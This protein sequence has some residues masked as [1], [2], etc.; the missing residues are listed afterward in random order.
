MADSSLQARGNAIYQYP[1]STSLVGVDLS[2]SRGLLLAADAAGNLT[3]NASTTVPAAAICLDGQIATKSS[4]IGI[5]E[6]MP[7]PTFV[8]LSGT[9]APFQR[10]QQ[11]A[12]GGVVVDVGPG[13]ARVVVGRLGDQGGVAGD[14]VPAC[15]CEG[16]ILA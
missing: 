10:I 8:K 14:I 4:T 7:G 9:V 6:L 5:L 3:V 16:N 2:A 1:G 15:L 13:T 11:A 12:D